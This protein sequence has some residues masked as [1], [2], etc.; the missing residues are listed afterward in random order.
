MCKK[1]CS[2]ILP[3]F[4][5]TSCLRKYATSCFFG[6]DILPS[7][8]RDTLPSQV[9]DILPRTV[10]SSGCLPTHEKPKGGKHR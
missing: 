3:R 10:S 1:A 4:R 8:R 9:R 5:A 7:L 6:C 2:D